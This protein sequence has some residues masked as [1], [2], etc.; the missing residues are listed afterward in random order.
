MSDVAVA[1]V[2]VPTAPLLK[3]TVLLPGVVSKP[4]PLMVIVVAVIG[5]LAVLLVTPGVTEATCTAEPLETPLVVTTAVKLPT[6]RWLLLE[7]VTVS[8][9]AVA[10]VTV[11]AAW[12]LNTTVLLAGVVLKPKPLMVTV[13][14]LAA[15]LAVLPVTIGATAGHLDRGAAA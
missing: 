1:E 12:P 14:A 13:V 15:R 10:A 5:R 3:A 2:T 7:N 11:P 9:L 6:A 4:A 8:E